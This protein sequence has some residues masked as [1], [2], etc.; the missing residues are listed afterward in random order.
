MSILHNDEHG[1]RISDHAHC[2]IQE[3]AALRITPREKTNPSL[4]SFKTSIFRK[5]SVA[6][7]ACVFVE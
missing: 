3:L 2:C 5:V 1:A 6:R 7:L 4:K